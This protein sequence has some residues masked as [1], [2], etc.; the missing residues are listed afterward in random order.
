M[1]RPRRPRLRV[2]QLEDRATPATLVAL[3]AMNRLLS[4]DSANPTKIVSSVRVS[5]LQPG[6]DLVGLDA[7]PATGQLYAPSNLGRLYVL[8]PRTG[9]ATAVSST[10]AAVRPTGGP[11]GFDFNPTVDRVRVT[12]AG[13]GELNYRLN[14]NDGMAVDGDPLTAGVQPDTALAFADG[15]A[16][17]GRNPAVVAAAYTNNFLG[18]TTTTLYGLDAGRDALVGIGGLNGT[19][20]P[21][22]G[23]LTTIGALGRNIGPAASFDIAPDGTTYAAVQIMNG[24]R[25]G[26]SRL[27]TVDLTT[28]AL[29]LGGSIGSGNAV[30]DGLAVLPRDEIA[31]GVTVSNRLVSFRA[32]DPANILTSFPVSG[33]TAGENVSGIDVRPATGE[34]FALTDANRVLRLDPATG[35]G[36]QVGAAVDPTLFAT[37]VAGGFDF[38]PAA[39]RLRLVNADNDNLRFNPVTFTPVDGDAVAPGV[40]AD[41]DLA[42]DAGDP[43]AMANPFVVAAAYDRNDNDGATATTLFG[44]DSAL[45]V[46]VRQGG[47]DGTPSPNGGLL[48]TVGALGVNPTEIAGLDISGAGAGGSGT[49]VAALQLEGET[50]SKIYN[51]NLATG[52]ATLVGTVGGGEALRDIAIAGPRVAFDATSLTVNEKA[53]TA[54]V[55]VT[56]T[57]GSFGTASVRFNTLAGTAVAGADFTAIADLDVTFAPGETRKVILV[58]ILQDRL[59]ESRETVFLTLSGL[60][61]TG[62]NA[63]IDGPGLTLTIVDDDGGD[64]LG[65]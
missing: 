2:Q 29:T 30:L 41:T 57:G 55:V 36:V 18:A 49:A 33:L 53:G 58:P 45:N 12:A 5:G 25:L 42:F 38:N 14:P 28:G 7:R 11:F 60:T 26:L 46:L 20:S 37:G 43:N 16:N 8:D 40:Q 39:D 61:G 22:G 17:A 13:T 64:G 48:F 27:A 1:P 19:P 34:L 10:P 44:I 15:D 47:V 6:E 51:L 3:T 50:V 56:R 9:A 35:R 31:Y 4:F 52:A 23:R 62:T 54:A 24:S 59:R 63:L 65:V 21:N 32:D